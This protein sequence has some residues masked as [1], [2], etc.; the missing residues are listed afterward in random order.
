MQQFGSSARMLNRPGPPSATFATRG[1]ALEKA[2][3]RQRCFY[4]FERN[5]DR[6]AAKLRELQPSRGFRLTDI[7]P[8]K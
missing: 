1:P 6:L 8:L 5:D 7:K 3:S 4:T 2:Q